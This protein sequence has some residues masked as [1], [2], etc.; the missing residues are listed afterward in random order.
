[1]RRRHLSN[2]MEGAATPPQIKSQVVLIEITLNLRLCK[3]SESLNN[4][5]NYLSYLIKNQEYYE[6]F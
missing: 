6:I 4:L 2:K 3:D 1:M 5:V